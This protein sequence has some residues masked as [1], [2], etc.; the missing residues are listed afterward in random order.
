V[1]PGSFNARRASVTTAA[2]AAELD[3][4]TI[5]GGV[6][7]AELMRRA[8]AAAA[9]IVQRECADALRGGV[10]VATGPGN[11]GGDGWI[12]A[13]LLA[14]EGVAVRVAEIVEAR[15]G[16]AI[17]ARDQAR[18]SVERAQSWSGEPW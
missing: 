12:V 6:A 11:N 10:Y 18:A 14:S 13:A 7:S 1:Q 4:R 17:A 3:A 9:R 8:G 2:E 5:A 15:S 16:D